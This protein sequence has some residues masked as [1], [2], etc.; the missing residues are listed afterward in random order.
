MYVWGSNQ[1]GQ[2]GKKT[3]QLQVNS[4]LQNTAYTDSKPFKIACGSY[5]TLCLS[6]RMPKMEE[7]VSDE[8]GFGGRSS[9]VLGQRSNQEEAKTA[10]PVAHDDETCPN[11]E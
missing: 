3:M 5:H 6:Y 7:D 9:S 11:M 1:Q 10:A 2:L 4:P 8:T